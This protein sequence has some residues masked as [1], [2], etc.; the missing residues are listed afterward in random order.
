MPRYALYLPFSLDAEDDRTAVLVANL[1]AHRNALL[2][3]QDGRVVETTDAPP[4]DR[5]L[6]PEDLRTR[7]HAVAAALDTVA[8][9]HTG[10]RDELDRMVEE[11]LSSPPSGSW[12]RSTVLRR[13]HYR[14]MSARNSPTTTHVHLL[15]NILASRIRDLLADMTRVIRV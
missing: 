11:A 15:V 4:P 8:A 9:G 1:L 2:M 5:L 10:E 6:A 3:T 7:G 14:W 13:V 12:S